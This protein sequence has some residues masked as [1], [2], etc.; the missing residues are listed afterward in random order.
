MSTPTTP[1]DTLPFRAATTI[2]QPT[3]H[4]V[5]HSPRLANHQPTDLAPRTLCG[6]TTAAAAEISLGDIDCTLC[7]CLSPSYMTWPTFGSTQ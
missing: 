4:L 1:T 2:D 5:I 3:T 7:L 6:R